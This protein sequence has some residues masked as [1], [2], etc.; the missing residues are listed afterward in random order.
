M[1]CWQHTFPCEQYHHSY[2][3]SLTWVVTSCEVGNDLLKVCAEILGENVP[4]VCRVIHRKGFNHTLVGA[5]VLWGLFIPSNGGVLTCSPSTSE[6]T[7]F[8]CLFVLTPALKRSVGNLTAIWCLVCF[9]V[10][11]VGDGAL[12]LQVT[13]TYDIAAQTHTLAGSHRLCLLL[14]EDV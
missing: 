13:H 14:S 11:T 10:A 2:D 4:F 12:E 7:L 6:V 1:I 8:V 9:V 5:L 3:M